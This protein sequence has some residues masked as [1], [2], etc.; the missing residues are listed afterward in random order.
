LKREIILS[1][2]LFL[3]G[4]KIPAQFINPPHGYVFNDSI[5][6]RIDILIDPDD[7]DL[8]MANPESNAEYSATFIFKTYLKSDTVPGVG[9]RIRGNTSRWSG[10][11]SYKIS[12]NTYD[13]EKKF[14]GLEKM[15]NLLLGISL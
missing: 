13:P 10:K 4:I 1:V 12:F 14:Y 2:A 7:L 3:I 5:I 11:K 15:N 6:P 8:I 9:F